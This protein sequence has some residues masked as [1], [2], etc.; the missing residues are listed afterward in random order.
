MIGGEGPDDRAGLVGGAA[1]GDEDL[2]AV[3][4]GP[5]LLALSLF[6]VRRATAPGFKKE[7]RASLPIYRYLVHAVITI[8]VLV[9]LQTEDATARPDGLE[10]VGAGGLATVLVTDSEE[11]A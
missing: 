9:V 5:A 3:G 10:L 1:I 6:A 11:V 2:E 4:L 8:L 7:L